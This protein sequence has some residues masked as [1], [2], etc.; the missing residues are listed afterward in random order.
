MQQKSTYRDDYFVGVGGL[1]LEFW[2][3]SDYMTLDII[4]WHKS[5][6]I[7]VVLLLDETFIRQIN[8]YTQ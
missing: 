1:S 8:L 3:D 6:E 5:I 2:T 7:S 4:I